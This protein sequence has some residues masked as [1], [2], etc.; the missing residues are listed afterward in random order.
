MKSITP[1]G[2][3]NYMW[4]HTKTGAFSGLQ[5]Q[6]LSVIIGSDGKVEQY[7]LTGTP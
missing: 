4:H 6:A 5:Q 2:R 7:S 3:T 1:E